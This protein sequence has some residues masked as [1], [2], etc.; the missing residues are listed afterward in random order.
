MADTDKT[1]AYWLD[2]ACYFEREGKDKSAEMALSRAIKLDIEEHEN[3]NPSLR[4]A[5]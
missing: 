1:A 2:R 3:G 5:A 4:R